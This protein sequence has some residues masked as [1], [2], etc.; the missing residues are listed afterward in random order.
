[1]LGQ[2]LWWAAIAPLEWAPLAW[3]APVPWVWL[4]RRDG[5]PGKRPYGALWLTSFVFY[6]AVLYWVT[7]PHW[8]TSIGWVALSAYLAIYFPLFIALSRVAVHALGCQP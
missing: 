3:L 5:L 4:V 7:L 1:M 2:V 6:L 8:A